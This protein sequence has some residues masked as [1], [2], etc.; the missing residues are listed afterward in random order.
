[1]HKI[2]ITVPFQWLG[3]GKNS[4]L[5]TT[6]WAQKVHVGIRPSLQNV[7]FHQY[8]HTVRPLSTMTTLNCVIKTLLSINST[9]IHIIT[10]YTTI[11]NRLQLCSTYLIYFFTKKNNATF[12][13]KFILE[14]IGYVHIKNLQIKLL[15]NHYNNC[16]FIH[17]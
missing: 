6:I 1:M 12:S 16:W 9:R 2:I 7:W 4:I 10:H 3:L 8:T 14:K 11:L 17:K 5:E 15:F 13:L